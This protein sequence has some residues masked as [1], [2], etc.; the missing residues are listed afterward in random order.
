V[1]TYRKKSVHYSSTIKQQVIRRIET[2][3]LSVSSAAREYG[4][5]G[6]MTIYRW[7]D[8]RDIIMGKEPNQ[9]K[10]NEEPKS[11]QE[12]AAE[13]EMLRQLLKQERLRS[14][15]YLTMIKIAEEQFNIPIE[16]KSG[17]KR[18]DK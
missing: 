4:I 15:A 17:A 8:R 7:L 1:K 2:G 10:P 3:E 16:K 13:V 5:G 14:E 11:Q 9:N 18:L 12:L 6:S